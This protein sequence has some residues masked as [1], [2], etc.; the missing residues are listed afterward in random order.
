MS[1][2]LC[3][4]LLKPASSGPRGP[5]KWFAWLVDKS[6][7]GYVRA[8]GLLI[9]HLILTML[10]LALAGGAVYFL[11]SHTPS[12]FLPIVAGNPAYLRWLDQET[13]GGGGTA[14]A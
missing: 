6:R 11:F 4:L 10:V 13:S 7:N 5:L 2:A 12:G 3:A 14:F 8:S 1:P 9:R